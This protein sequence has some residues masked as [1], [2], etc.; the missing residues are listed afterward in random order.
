MK[1]R[2]ILIA[3]LV[4]ASLASCDD[5]LDVETPSSFDYDYAY[6]T[7]ADAEMALNGLY[8][9][10]NSVSS[11]ITGGNL[12][13]N[14]DLDFNAYSGETSGT[15]NP[16]RFDC[17]AE[18]STARSFWQN[19]YNAIEHCNIFIDQMSKSSF[20]EDGD[21]TA[22]QMLGE[23]KCLRA[24]FY[25]E[26]VWYFGDIPYTLEP[27]YNYG[28]EIF[29]VVDRHQ[30]LDDLIADL[31]D[32]AKDMQFAADITNGVEHASKEF[33]WSMIAR[34]AMT[35]GG[36][37]LMPDKANRASYGKMERPANYLEYYKTAADYCDS[38][39]TL[40]NHALNKSFV[41]VFV[42][43][44][45]YV[46][47]NSD[48]PIFEIPYTK[49][50]SGNI[51]YVH[52]YKFNAQNGQT[53]YS[54]GETS[55]AVGLHPLVRYLFDEEDV[56]RDYLI[57]MWNYTYDGIPT[58]EPNAYKVYNNKWSKLWSNSP[59]GNSSTGSTGINFPYMRYTDVL[60]TYAE[61]INE[62]ENGVSGANGQKAIDAFKEVRSRAFRNSENAA[63]KVDA[64]IATAAGSQESFLKAVLDE[65]MFEFAG[66]NLRWKDLVRNNLYAEKLAYAFLRMF[67]V[68]ENNAYPSGYTESVSIYDGKNDEFWDQIP[69]TIGY[70]IVE[71]P[72]KTVNNPRTAT[73]PNNQLDVLE[74]YNLY[75]NKVVP[76]GSEWQRG[77]YYENWCKDGSFNGSVLY[78]YYGFVRGVDTNSS[79][80][81]VVV[82][83]TTTTPL[84]EVRD[85]STLPVV[86]YILP[87]P[88]A[89]IQD[90]G[91][92]YVNYYG[93]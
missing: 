87:Y 80:V 86:R 57:G 6:G 73:F 84:P 8:A 62:L 66:E 77:S 81:V 37:T 38:V 10:L 74:F 27:S 18:S 51:G 60:L 82:N 32:A 65:R 47:N 48:D 68:A 28:K 41:D 13:L 12:I 20:V 3:G 43:E 71:N 90:S 52:G 30:I 34:I 19:S 59:L 64:Y 58:T 53:N 24:I 92:A 56:R 39:M 9:K 67:G 23:A 1:L 79:D 40:S 69:M 42:D 49:E 76:S 36:Y 31:K 45:N 61:A 88:Q 63:D 78:S 17:T 16:R 33:A 93:Y 25:F 35:N 15:N 72:S 89:A 14:S 83:N 55:G 46:V 75:E 21:K 2:N 50:T 4:T 44:C 85:A 7:L 26:M 91:N 54:W 5:Y 11:S 29:D 70:K 22:L